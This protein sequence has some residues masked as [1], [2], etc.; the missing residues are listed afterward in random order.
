MKIFAVILFVSCVLASCSYINR[1]MG[2]DDD[3]LIEEV[4]ESAIKSKSS[5][6]IDLTPGS[7]E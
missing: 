1:C 3:N 5:I 6:D 2:L 4:V 7:I